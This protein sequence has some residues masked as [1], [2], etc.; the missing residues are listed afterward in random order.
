[1]GLIE[2]LEF[3]L[4]IEQIMG[5]KKKIDL[6]RMFAQLNAEFFAGRLPEYSVIFSAQIRGPKKG[7]SDSKE[8]IQL[9]K[10]I[11]DDPKL[12]RRT[13][14]HEMC[15]HGC[16]G[17]GKTFI[18]ELDRLATLGE[19]WAAEEAE[20]YRKKAISWNDLMRETKQSLEEWA[21]HS[22]RSSKATSFK[23][24][25]LRVR[26][27]LSLSAK[28]IDKKLPWLRASWRN[29]VQEAKLAAEQRAEAQK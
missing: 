25:H 6:N 10:E 29:A 17:H 4:N 3:K 24:I 20:E 15:H 2:C 28:E 13:L 9:A 14:I 5:K 18:A 16:P 1:M 19:E 7:Q 21:A 23:A 12:L 8:R 22:V 11:A 26:Q 27:E